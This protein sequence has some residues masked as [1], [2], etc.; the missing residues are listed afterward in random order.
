MEFQDNI[1][2][3]K[4]HKKSIYQNKVHLILNLL[5]PSILIDRKMPDFKT[6]QVQIFVVRNLFIYLDTI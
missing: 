4:N 1:Y 3:D 2:F 6:S 5:Q